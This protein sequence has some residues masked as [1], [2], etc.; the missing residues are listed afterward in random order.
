M[1]GFL[2]CCVMLAA[3]CSAPE[4]KPSFDVAGVKPTPDGDTATLTGWFVLNDRSFRLYPTLTKPDDDAKCISGVLL[5][6]AG[7]PPPEYSNRPMSISGYVYDVKDDAAQ[8]AANPCG[9]SVILEAVDVM[10]P[11]S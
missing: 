7:V 3:G 8:G 9:S 6:L 10:T 11:E 2:V 1:R 5:S 4:A